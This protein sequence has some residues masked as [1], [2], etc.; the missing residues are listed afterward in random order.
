MRVFPTDSIL[1]GL[2]SKTFKIK[3]CY[4]HLG[5]CLR[6]K[7]SEP[8]TNI[9]DNIFFKDY[10]TCAYILNLFEEWSIEHDSYCIKLSLS[11]YRHFYLFAKNQSFRS[12]QL[13]L[14]NFLR[15]VISTIRNPNDI[16]LRIPPFLTI[17]NFSRDRVLEDLNLIFSRAQI[18]NLKNGKKAHD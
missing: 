7:I 10:F 8:N 2:C 17:E 13:Y 9:L 4:L 14:D 18:F 3:D 12:P 5:E 6:D 1:C 11:I 16:Y 15:A